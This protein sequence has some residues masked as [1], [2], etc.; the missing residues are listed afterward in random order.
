MNTR[1]ALR[2]ADPARHLPPASLEERDEQLLREILAAKSTARPATT[3]PGAGGIRRRP[4]RLAWRTGLATGIV[5]VAVIAA[6][7]AVIRAVPPTT[8][9]GLASPTNT[10]TP[11]SLEATLTDRLSRVDADQAADPNAPAMVWTQNGESTIGG[12][13]DLTGK[14]PVIA[15][16]CSD[17]GSIA[18]QV[19]GR[20]NTTL[21][22][23]NLSAIGP[24]DLTGGPDTPSDSVGITVVAT[25]GNPRFIAKLIAVAT[26]RTSA[27]TC[28]PDDLTGT[29]S[30]M[31]GAAG[32]D[33]GTITLTNN[34]TTTCTIHGQPAAYLTNKAGGPR[35]GATSGT[36][37]VT[38]GQLVA[39]VVLPPGE[40]ATIA[41]SITNISGYRK[42]DGTYYPT[43]G[44]AITGAGWTLTWTG[45]KH[46]KFIPFASGTR[47]LCSNPTTRTSHIGTPSGPLV[48]QTTP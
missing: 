44:H 16:A 17:G 38:S 42:S 45:T 22:C 13:I 23:T 11:P 19:S 40:K 21:D 4:P 32:T 9:P 1:D 18:I 34:G 20:P 43:C 5:A 25:S 28:D 29:A 35:I 47:P 7:I 33:H 46:T 3:P 41:V 10:S 27:P 48:G 24:I 14:T 39:T 12:A 31:E 30:R 6:S 15:A 26:D 8:T 2:S 36:D 37:P